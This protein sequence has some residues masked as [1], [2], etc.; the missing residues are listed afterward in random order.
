MDLKRLTASILA[1][2]LALSG[3]GSILV[4]NSQPESVQAIDLTEDPAIRRNDDDGPPVLEAVDDDD[5]LG[6]GDSTRGDDGT[7][8]GDNTGD[9]D[10]TRGDDGTDGGDNT[11]DDT[12]TGG[13]TGAGDTTD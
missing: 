9:G 3:I 1:A 7:D 4:L 10:S 12:N 8:G 5:D 13:D 6:D 2:A 11:G